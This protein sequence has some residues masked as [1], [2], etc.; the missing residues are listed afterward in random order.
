[1]GTYYMATLLFKTYFKVR[2][3]S[4]LERIDAGPG[5]SPDDVSLTAQINRAMQEHHQG[6]WSC[7]SRGLFSLPDRASRKQVTWVASRRVINTG[8]SSQQQVTYLYYMG[9][10]AFLREDYGEAEKQFCVALGLIHHKARRNVESVACALFPPNPANLSDLPP[11]VQTDPR[12]SDPCPP[13]PRCPALQEAS[14]P[15]GSTGR[16]LR[17]VH[18][19]VQER[20]R[21][22]VRSTVA[23]STEE[24]DGEGDILDRREGE[25]RCRPGAVEE[26]VSRSFSPSAEGGV[27]EPRD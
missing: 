22:A 6:N 14:P 13:S 12:L 8:P 11:L 7:R 17:P 23:E 27:E 19:S 16:R 10:F 15:F 4:L 20:G 24:A 1:M 25:G 26:G 2:S 5:R 18:R 9:V 21:A 3:Y